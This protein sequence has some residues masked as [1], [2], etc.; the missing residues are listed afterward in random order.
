MNAQGLGSKFGGGDARKMLLPLN[1]A[2]SIL[3]IAVQTLKF[4]H[5]LAQM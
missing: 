1:S 5:K 3:D 2:R 4:G